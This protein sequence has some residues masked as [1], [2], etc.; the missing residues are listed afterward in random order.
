ML[1]F[2]GWRFNRDKA[3]FR[4]RAKLIPPFLFWIRLSSSRKL[5]SSDQCCPFS[6]DLAH[7]PP[8][9]VLC[10][11]QRPRLEGGGTRGFPFTVA[12]PASAAGPVAPDSST[13]AGTFAAPSGG[14]VPPRRPTP[15]TGRRGRPLA[16]R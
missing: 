13:T 8:S 2:P 6:M 15:P 12:A 11:S 7:Y 5:T 4:K 3:I 9:D 14:Q 1:S 16:A 10:A